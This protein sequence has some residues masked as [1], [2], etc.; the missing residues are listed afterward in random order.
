MIRNLFTRLR[1][2]EPLPDGVAL[3]LE[4]RERVL[5]WGRVAGGGIAA[6]T[7]VGL[8]VQPGDGDRAVLHR[9][10]DIARATWADGH[11]DVEDMDG[12]TASY[13]LTEPRGVPQAVREHVDA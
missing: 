8:R 7:D 10:H 11:L 5:T 12:A 3:P 9:W 2:A 4:K 1:G 13:R 6:A